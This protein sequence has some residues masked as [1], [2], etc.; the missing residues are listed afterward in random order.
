MSSTSSLDG[1]YTRGVAQPGLCSSPGC[2]WKMVGRVNT[3]VC[4]CNQ[5]LCNAYLPKACYYGS[6]CPRP[7]SPYSSSVRTVDSTTGGCAKMSTTSSPDGIY[8]RNDAPPNV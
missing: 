2:L 7:F 8:T 6:N 3:W 1:I 5:D 4:C